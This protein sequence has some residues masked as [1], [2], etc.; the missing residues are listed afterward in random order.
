MKR[1]ILI[2]LLTLLFACKKTEETNN[3]FPFISVNESINLN[4]PQYINLR[5]PGNSVYITG[6]HRGIVIYNVNGKDFKAF[7]RACPNHIDSCLPM[8]IKNDI[9]LKCSC[10]NVEYNILN[11]SPLVGKSTCFAKEYN[12]E[13]LNGTVLRITNF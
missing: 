7:D 8:T 10:N 5:T 4:L 1:V 13:N 12:V 3:C 6:G 9:R 2:S 11:G